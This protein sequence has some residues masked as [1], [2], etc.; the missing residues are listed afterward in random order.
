MENAENTCI[1]VLPLLTEDPASD[2][3]IRSGIRFEQLLA[4]FTEFRRTGDVNNWDVFQ[5]MVLALVFG[6]G[7]KSWCMGSGVLVAPG[8]A[9]C[10]THVMQSH[11]EDIM[12]LRLE[13]ICFGIGSQGVQGWRIRD[14][15]ITQGS[16]V[17]IIGLQFASEIPPN[18]TF[19]KASITTRLPAIGESLTVSGFR[20]A[21]NVFHSGVPGEAQLGALL[22]ISMGTVTQQ[23]PLGRDK[24]L[25]PWPALEIDCPAWGAMS[26]GPVFDARG[27]LVGLIS[28][29]W[30]TEDEP[31]PMIC[32]LLWPILASH[33]RGG[34]PVSHEQKSLLELA[35]SFCVIDR[36][37]AIKIVF[38]TGTNRMKLLYAPWT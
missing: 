2:P 37:D 7:K 35:G 15:R 34:W 25:V 12:Q 16:D 10:A 26:G 3:Q 8:I 22:K 19:Y 33:F 32:S 27:Y 36:P 9:L 18:Q 38:D 20:P 29:S 23:F 31:S 6:D 13:G 21:Q 14:V 17:C 11:I 24:L 5:G 4:A 1:G 28:R 30:E